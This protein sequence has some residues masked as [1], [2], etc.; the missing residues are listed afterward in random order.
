VR[1]TSKSYELING[2]R[3]VAGTFI[4]AEGAI[5]EK[6]PALFVVA[7]TTLRKREYLKF[8]GECSCKDS[9]GFIRDMYLSINTPVRI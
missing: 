5:T 9:L 2:R 8:V 7:A 1:F 4:S 3:F 6:K